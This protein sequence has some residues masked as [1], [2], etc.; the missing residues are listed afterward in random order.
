[1]PSTVSIFTAAQRGHRSFEHPS[2]RHGI[3]T[4]FLLD[5]LRGKAAA[6][7]VSEITFQI[8]AKYVTDSVERESAVLLNVPLADAQRPNFMSDTMRSAVLVARV[9]KDQPQPNEKATASQNMEANKSTFDGSHTGQVRN[10]NGLGMKMVWLP[11]GRFTMGSPRT[12]NDRGYGED[13][14]EVTL[15]RGFWLG[16]TEVTQQQWTSLTGTE[17]WKG[18]ENVREGANYA[19]SY[20]SWNDAVVFTKILTEQEQ[21]AGRL[22]KDWQ[23]ELPT[24]AQWE[25]ACRAGTSTSYSFGDDRSQLS[26]YA[27]YRDKE[28]EYKEGHAREVGKKKPNDFGLY[29]MHGN[30]TEWCI[31]ILIGKL[32]GGSDPRVETGGNVA[33]KTQR[34]GCWGSANWSCRTAYRYMNAPNFRDSQ[35]GFRVA[36]VRMHAAASR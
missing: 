13:Q 5:G 11:A 20:I 16:Q 15:T 2:L 26:D 21:L 10:D 17:P 35:V 30:V 4:H 22:P 32:P 12:E 18:K 36:L 19:A 1:M 34:G 33:D 28:G 14:V 25:Y 27:W 23:Y 3:F 8:L 9:D 31:D 7:G 29:D 24:E 6:P